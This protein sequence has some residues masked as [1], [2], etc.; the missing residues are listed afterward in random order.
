MLGKRD[1]RKGW[2]KVY[3]ENNPKKHHYLPRFYLSGFTNTMNEDSRFYVLDGL[4]PSDW[5]P[6]LE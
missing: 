5:T 2:N 1:R 6:G 4:N 3:M